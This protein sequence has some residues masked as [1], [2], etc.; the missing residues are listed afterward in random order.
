MTDHTPPTGQQLNDIETVI[1]AYQQHPDL[2]FACCSAHPAADAAT[3]LLA[4]VRRLR[5]ALAKEEQAHGETID[6]R[7][8][9]QEIADKLAYAVA[10]VEVI[11]EHSSMNCPWTNAYE[12]ITP[13]AEVEKLRQE[14]AAIRDQTIAWAADVV[15][16]KLT[17]EPDHGRA[18]AIYEL[19][20]HL[21]GE[22]P[23]TCAR[24]GGLH[25]GECRKYVPGHEL[26]SR[27]NALAAY[28]RECSA[29]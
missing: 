2:G 11:G 20:L 14:S 9:A 6:D 24:T 13:A 26:I 19:L 12:L 18:S 16:A 23:C 28:R 17:A 25:T 10:P 22:L 21:R 3:A 8:R 15:D 7:D 5:A 1:D 27:H 4:E 29:P